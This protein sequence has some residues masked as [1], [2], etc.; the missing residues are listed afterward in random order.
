MR[1]SV[2]HVKESLDRHGFWY[3]VWHYGAHE[4]WTIFVATRMLKRESAA[5]RE[6][7]N[8]HYSK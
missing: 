8:W 4:M 5:Q 6:H 1:P 7:A 2:F 3:V